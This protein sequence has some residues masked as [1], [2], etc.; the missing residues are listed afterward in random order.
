MNMKHEEVNEVPAI[1]L[2]ELEPLPIGQV[3]ELTGTA[4]D[5]G[6]DFDNIVW[7]NF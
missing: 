2:A 3:S 4:G 6:G 5:G 1:E 7:G